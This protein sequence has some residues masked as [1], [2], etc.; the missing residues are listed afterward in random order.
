MRHDRLTTDRK[1]LVASLRNLERGRFVHLGR[2]ERRQLVSSI[3]RRINDLD[4]K[5][6]AGA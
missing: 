3:R 4:N 1:R 6:E 2:E 5:L